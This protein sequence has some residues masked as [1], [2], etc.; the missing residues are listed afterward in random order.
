MS[1]LLSITLSDVAAPLP[2][3]IAITLFRIS[4][5]SSKS[6]G[7]DGIYQR[8]SILH[9]LNNNRTICNR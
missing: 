7:T 2:A 4:S 5:D 6:G 1:F 8:K 3:F 9:M